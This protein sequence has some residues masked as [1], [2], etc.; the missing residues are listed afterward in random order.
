MHDKLRLR[1]K[2]RGYLTI[3]DLEA[4]YT[5]KWKDIDFKQL[6]TT[7]YQGGI[8]TDMCNHCQFF[9]VH[10]C[11]DDFHIYNVGEPGAN[12][13]FTEYNLNICENFKKNQLKN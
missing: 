13:S 11:P 12:G 5:M 6:I 2:I 8:Q 3:E 10:T 4:H 9:S 1:E 7:H